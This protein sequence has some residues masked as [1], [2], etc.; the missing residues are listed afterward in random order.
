MP[1][2]RSPEGD[3]SQRA[4]PP[5]RVRRSI[6][7]TRANRWLALFVGAR[8]AATAVAAALLLAH[9]VTDH[10]GLLITL[11]VAYGAVSALTAAR[12]PGYHRLA[13]VW[14]LDATIALALVL[15]S[16][17]WRSPFYLVALTSLVLPATTLPFKRALAF[18]GAFTTAYFAVALATGIDWQTLET[19]ARLESFATHLMMPMLVVLALAYSGGLLSRLE[20]ERNRSEELALDAERRR[21]ALELH[22][23]AKQRVHAAHLVLSAVGHAGPK[24]GRRAAITHAMGELRAAAAELDANLSELRA[25]FGPRSLESALRE[26]AAELKSVAGDL[27][28]EVTGEAPELPGFLAAHAFHIVSE[29]MTN[30]AQHA[31]AQQIS[32]GLSYGDGVVQVVV[33]DDGS[34]MA[35]LPVPSGHGI[36]SMVE[37]AE[38]LGGTVTISPTNKDTRGTAVRLVVPLDPGE[39]P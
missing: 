23:S 19:T 34:G 2:T 14:T 17:Q 3:I 15:G 13:A 18:G 35:D 33:S 11:G 36:R 28:I 21:I 24:D 16:E 27:R 38:I 29:A 12:W 30:A 25:P 26:R 1:T 4:A 20:E 7:R 5:T 8:I 37:R 39:A 31:G 32:V 10:D 9:R 6:S 22:D